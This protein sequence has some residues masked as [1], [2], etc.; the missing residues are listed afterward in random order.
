MDK[1]TETKGD[2]ALFAKYGNGKNCSEYC[3]LYFK[4]RVAGK[5]N[6]STIISRTLR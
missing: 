6:L 1:S 4:G 2:M 5:N 3:R